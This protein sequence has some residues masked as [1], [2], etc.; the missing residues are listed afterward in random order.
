MEKYKNIEV[1]DLTKSELKEEK[2]K[3]EIDNNDSFVKEDKKKEIKKEIEKKHSY[4][5]NDEDD[6][7]DK[8]ISRKSSIFDYEDIKKEDVFNQILYISSNHDNN[9][10]TLGTYLGFKIYSLF[11]KE[12]ELIYQFQF[13]PIE[14][15]KIIEMLYTSQ[16]VVLVGKKESKY[17]SPKKLTFFDLGEKKIIYSLKSL[18]SEIKLLRL[19]KKRLIIYGDKSIFIYN[20]SKLRLIHTIKFEEDIITIEKSFYQGQICLSPNSE[21]NNYLVYSISQYNGILKIFDVLYLTYVNFIQAHKNPILKLCINS[22]GNLLASCSKKNGTIKVFHLP[23]GENFFKFKRGYTY[24]IITG[25]NFSIIGNNKLVV[26]SGSGN[27]HFYD[28]DKP[29][30]KDDKEKK[31][32]LD[33]Y[34]NKIYQKVNKECKN[35]LNNKSLT[36]TVNIKD[37]K[38]ENLIFFRK[39]IVPD[40]KNNMNIIAITLEGFFFS[41]RIDTENFI[42][43]NIYKKY[44]DSIKLKHN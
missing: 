5:N 24:N 33:G 31:V 21:E 9:Y 43:E 30:I 26:S 12:I 7:K 32:N 13:D 29:N 36:S 2:I 41:I 34:L 22:K 14:P 39:G 1:Q 25:M 16:L 10:I 37:L 17:L 20:L 6:I 28:L 8:K 18:N 38:G 23:K 3:E 19:N 4:D 40:N 42:L 15:V 27:I 11:K 44:L 35:Y